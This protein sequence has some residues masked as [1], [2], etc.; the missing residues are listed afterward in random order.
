MNALN[1]TKST[2]E[3]AVKR[4]A[5]PDVQTEILAWQ[6]AQ[7]SATSANL[8]DLMNHLTRI[9]HDQADC[10]ALWFSMPDENGLCSQFHPV[11]DRDDDPVW[12]V[13]EDLARS[14]VDKSLQT[15]LQQHTSF[16]PDAQLIVCPVGQA[17]PDQEFHPCGVWVG[18]FSTEEQTKVRQNWLMSMIAQTTAA[19]FAMKRFSQIES[20]VKDTG[21]LLTTVVSLNKTDNIQQTCTV[22]CNQ[23]RKQFSAEMVA[24]SVVDGRDSFRLTAISD[25][26]QIDFAAAWTS[27]VAAACAVAGHVG[28]PVA[29]SVLESDNAEKP[30]VG[31]NEPLERFCVKHGADACVSL[32]LLRDDGSACGTVL[33]AT[34]GQR[35]SHPSTVEQFDRTCQMLGPHVDIVSRAN[36]GPR[37]WLGRKFDKLRSTNWTRNLLYGLAAL[38]LAMCIPLPYRISCDCT[39]QPVK[40]RFLAAPYDGILDHADVK[41]GD[42]VSENDVLAHMDDGNLR[43]EL[44]GLQAELAAA[45]K[46]RDSALAQ[47]EVAQSQIARSEMR[48][49]QAQIDLVNE[50]LK[51]LEIRSPIDGMV[52]AGDLEKAEGA[53]LEMG[54]TVFEVAPL[55]RMLVEVAIEQSEIGYARPGMPVD[56][57][58]NAF[59]FQSWEG[60][61][62]NICPSTE[63]VNDKAVF[64]AE[65]EIANQELKLKPGMEGTAKVRGDLACIGWSLFHRP[66]ESV[67]Y[68][69]VW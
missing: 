32:P 29:F 62:K 22:L 59:P 30:E 12:T 19:W 64:V 67:R 43:I 7:A 35:L 46:K 36:Q 16:Q 11:P 56:I 54:Q 2:P 6:L 13:V 34:S 48:R 49:H 33:V 47:G 21:E 39:I 28:Q 37:Q 55:D 5:E 52:V 26:E 63:I 20:R 53:P 38:T 68:W 15:G 24:V 14:I 44:S 58:L 8:N 40:R 45:K 57:K 4:S 42:L 27:D 23:L 60:T 61:V 51:N 41:L 9:I 3:A 50:K 66:W 17:S 18:C 1:F 25:V 10:L 69:T 31:D 65:V